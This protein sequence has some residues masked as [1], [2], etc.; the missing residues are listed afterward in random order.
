[1]AEPA[2]PLTCKLRRDRLEAP[3]QCIDGTDR[4]PYVHVQSHSQQEE[5][6]LLVVPA[7]YG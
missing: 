2:I 7:K 6:R 3:A 5:E 1:M 4:P